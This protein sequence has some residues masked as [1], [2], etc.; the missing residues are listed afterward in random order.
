M[1]FLSIFSLSIIHLSIILS[2]FHILSWLSPIRLEIM[3]TIPKDQTNQI[4]IVNQLE[5]EKK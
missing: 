5:I 3:E 1:N 4:S 2:L